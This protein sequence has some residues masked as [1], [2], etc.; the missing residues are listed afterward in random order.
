MLIESTIKYHYLARVVVV[1]TFMMVVVMALV[2][3]IV[4]VVTMITLQVF[5]SQCIMRMLLRCWLA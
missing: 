4:I 5:A 3:E 2:M 1:A